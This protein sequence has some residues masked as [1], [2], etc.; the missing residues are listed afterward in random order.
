MSAYEMGIDFNDDDDDDEEDDV[1][2]VHD[3]ATETLPRLPIYHPAY[4]LVEKAVPAALNVLSD[5][6]LD[7][8][9][10]DLEVQHL[11]DEIKALLKIPYGQAVRL[12]LVGDTGVGKSAVLN[13]LLGIPNLTAEVSL[14]SNFGTGVWLTVF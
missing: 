13:G 4:K 7:N 5:F 2:T 12:G 9:Y 6:I 10:I 3:P 11:L 1:D 8:G 14:Y